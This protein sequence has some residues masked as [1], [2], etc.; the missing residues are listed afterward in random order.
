MKILL[1]EAPVDDF[2][3]QD[4]K[5]KILSAQN[6]KYQEAKRTVEN[7]SLFQLM[8]YLPSLERE[9]H[10]KLLKLAKALF[11]YK[12]P[13]IKERIDKGTITLNVNFSNSPN[14]RTT[15]QTISPENIENVKKIDSSFDERVKAGTYRTYIVPNGATAINFITAAN[16]ATVIL[17]RK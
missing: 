8:Q 14:P 2:L 13:K 12:F 9:H 10:D 16:T 1:Y 15:K 5:E 17:I 4:A 7:L 6:R 11:F 3:S